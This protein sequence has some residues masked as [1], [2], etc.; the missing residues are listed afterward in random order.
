MSAE[1]WIET[2]TAR[3]K[4]RED[5]LLE[6]WVRDGARE[7]LD[8]SKENMAAIARLVTEPTPVLA[9]MAGIREATAEAREY[10]RNSEISE[11]IISKVA[12]VVDSPVSM[13]IGNV[14][15]RVNRPQKPRR[16]FTSKE[17]A[18]V[19]LKEDSG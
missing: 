2:T 13:V 19:W 14:Y 6:F 12:L 4:L 5:G 11:R 17:E 1:Q 9:L 8:T 16:I 3:I 7:T 18:E 10:F 15:L